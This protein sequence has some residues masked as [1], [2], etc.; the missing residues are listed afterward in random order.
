MNLVWSFIQEHAPAAGQAAAEHAESPNVFAFTWNVSFWTVLIFLVLLSVLIKFA[1]PPIL[2]Y[3]NAR[4]K[5][6]QDTLDETR[7]QQE[8]AAR[9][10]EEQRKQ[11]AQARTEAQQIIAEGKSAAE[12]LRQD[13]LN[14]AREE[15]EEIIARA[16]ADIEAERA[17]AV[18][19]VRREAVE[20]A[21]AAASRLIEQRLDQEADRRLVNEYLA[22]VTPTVG[23]GR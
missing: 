1:F 23:A 3:A 17:R 13:L 2:G 9:L 10:L 8:E 6:I 5:R 18:E 4:E 14:R 12:K 22:K 7:R 15:Q 11:L 21:L 16:K 19:S 20:V